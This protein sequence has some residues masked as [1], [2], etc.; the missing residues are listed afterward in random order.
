MLLHLDPIATTGRPLLMV[1]HELGLDLPVRE[2]SLQAGDH[3]TPEYLRL[4]PNG[5]VPVLED[6][7]FVLTESG[8]ILRYIA[9]G[10]SLLPTAPRAA[11]RLEEALDWFKTGFA[12]DYCHDFAYPL[13]LPKLRHPD[14]AVQADLT[15][16]ALQRSERRFEVLDRHMLGDGRTF[17]C[18]EALT[19][20][21]F[22]AAVM[23]SLG[24]PLGFPVSD[25]RNVATW[26]GRI[27][28][29]PSWAAG[30][31]AFVAYVE[32]ARADG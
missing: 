12:T 7:D 13:L 17:L 29:L 18:G 6:G 25:Y 27:T 26:L 31:A 16:R 28:A 22:V 21:D 2:I 14:E 1:R 9:Q 30:N 32:A 24:Q 15:A 4:N 11:A 20:A 3:L 23:V 8:A 5:Q 19:I 10:S